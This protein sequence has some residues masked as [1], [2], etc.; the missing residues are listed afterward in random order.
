MAIHDVAG[1]R[2]Y[3]VGDILHEFLGHIFAS[4]L[5]TL[6]PKNPKTFSKILGFS[7][8]EWEQHCTINF[9]N[10]M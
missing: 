8:P 1:G 10:S 2:V 5:R 9:L 6:K 7:S 4:G 3:H